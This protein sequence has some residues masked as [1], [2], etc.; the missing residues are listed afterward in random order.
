MKH[1]LVRMALV[2]QQKFEAQKVVEL[3]VDAH[4][5]DQFDTGQID[6]TQDT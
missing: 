4:L 3:E 2:R 1:S 5:S 6:C